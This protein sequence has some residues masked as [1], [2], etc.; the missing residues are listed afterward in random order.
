MIRQ[1][2]QKRIDARE[3]YMH[4]ISCLVQIVLLLTVRLSMMTDDFYRAH[5]ANGYNISIISYTSMYLRTQLTQNY[6]C[7]STH[8]RAC[9][10]L[11][12]KREPTASVCQARARSLFGVGLEEQDA[13]QET[14][15][16]TSNSSTSRAGS[17]QQQ[18]QVTLPTSSISGT[19]TGLCL[20]PLQHMDGVGIYQQVT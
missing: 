14:D 18:Q 4:L 3:M 2:L 20:Y 7:A 19:I 9:S 1:V 13:R 10:R 5:T 17:E 8:S 16:D 15:H 6:D 12:A 11:F